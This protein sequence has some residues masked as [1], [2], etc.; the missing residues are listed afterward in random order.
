VPSGDA[1][2]EGLVDEF[3]FGSLLAVSSER[4]RCMCLS[5]EVGRRAAVAGR[6]K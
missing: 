2:G 1:G 5:W 6:A 4:G 3:Q